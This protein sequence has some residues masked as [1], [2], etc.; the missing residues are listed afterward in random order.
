MADDI[1]VAQVNEITEHIIYKR[2]ADA[3]KNPKNKQLLKAISDDEMKHYKFWKSV[4]KK[5]V[6]PSVGKVWLYTTMA[7]LFGLSF[8]LKL[9]ERGERLAQ[10]A[11]HGLE[12]KH[13]GSHQIMLDEQKHEKQLLAMLEEEKLEYASSIVLGLNDA[14]VE[15]TGALAGFTF[16]IQEGRTIAVIGLITGIAAALSMS[17]S[18]YLSA[19]EERGKKTPLKSAV[20]TGVAYLITVIVLITPFFLISTFAALAVSLTLALAVIFGYTYYISVAKDLRFWP[21]F[22]QMAAISLAVSLISFGIGWALKT[23]GIST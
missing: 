20:Y 6:S 8:T 21:R 19:I 13:V 22:L 18:A 5:E 15:L 9:M 16:A 2:L 14:L 12:R 17:A 11:Y 10:K 23:A 3:D 4:S 7:K 1:L